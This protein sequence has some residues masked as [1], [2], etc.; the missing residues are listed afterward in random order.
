MPPLAP[1]PNLV[2]LKSVDNKAIANILYETADLLEID[3]QDSFRV[4][5]YRNAAQAIENL[6]QPIKE[7]IADP[8]QVLA[9]PGIGKGMLLNLQELFKDG[10]LS[11]QTGLLEKYHPSMLQLLKIQGL[12]PK[13]IALIWSAYQVSDID[14]VEKLAREGKIRELPR[15]GEKHEA[16]LLKAIED[17]RR[18]GGRFLIDAAEAEAEKLIAYLEKYPGIDKITPAGSLRRGRETVGDLDILV[19][20]TACTSE[21]GRQKAIAYVAQYPPL[22]DVIA[23]GD[24]KISFHLRSGMQVDVRLLPPESFGAA[25]QYFTGSKAH[26]VA[27]RQRALKMGYTL[28]EYSLAA[29]DGATPVA[30]KTEEEIYAKLNLDYIPPEMRENLGEIDLAKDHALPPLITQAH[31]RGDVH[32][33]T[34]ETD[35]RNT[36]E[37]MAEAAKAR[38]YQYM[39]ITDHSKNLAF[40]NG[41]DDQRAVAHIQRIR[42][43]GKQIEGITI[44]AGIEVDILAD[45]NL[46]LSDDVLAEMDIVIASVHSVFNQEPAKMTDRLL[47]A[48]ANPNTSIIGHPTGRIQLRRDAYAFDM[49][50]ILTVAAKNKVAMELNSYPDRLDL[51]DVHLR[52]AKQQGVK[53]VINT[54]S[55]HTSHMEKIRYGVL[56]A[57]RAWLT[58]NDVLNT[59]P[60]QQFAK[61]MK[62]AW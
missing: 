53:I 49:H 48:I 43:A 6:S 19:T 62:H 16:K 41:L 29:L 24:N 61:A 28:N 44:F 14:G 54:D 20:G 46:D 12:G 37:E 2:Y 17:Y 23:S 57:R 58:K 39:A 33:H 25:M 55:H 9:I 11:I 42:E 4:R 26:N 13:T 8:K 47:K 15:M 10:K 56:Q 30:G 32:M 7:L 60:P 51:N 40:A 21:D 3:A 22:M 34:V 52:Q 1:P 5:S 36:I 50:A 38:G 27:L 35:G 18:I 31:L 59:L 45:G